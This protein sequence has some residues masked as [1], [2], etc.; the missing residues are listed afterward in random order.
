VRVTTARDFRGKQATYDS[1][2][3]TDF[4]TPPGTVVVAAAPG[5]V[6][7]VSSEFNRG[8]LKVFIDHGRGLVTTS[9]HLARA[10]VRPGQDVA[11]GEPIALSGMSG[12]DGFLL[13]PLSSPHLHF[14]VWLDGTPVDPFARPG[15]QALWRT[16]NEPSPHVPGV[17]PADDT[18]VPTPWDEAAV[19][20]AIAACRH[21]GARAEME[22]F[23]D[24]EE[25]A[26]AV[27]F[28]RNYYPTR[29]TE[30]PALE[31][32]RHERQPWLDLPFSHEDYD[33]V[34]WPTKG[35]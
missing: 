1:H 29:F 11:R 32:Q 6:L 31:R 15:E 14:N 28:Q 27:L 12:I 10:L 18:F 26:M 22:A 24:P 21:E 4:A 7:R 35:G 8:G 13:F 16:G 30:R 20:R 19:A 23:R 3:G 25:R 34:A 33:G 2:N 5:R 17:S 9:N